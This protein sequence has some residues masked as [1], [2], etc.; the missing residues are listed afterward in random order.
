MNVALLR[1]I[2]NDLPDDLIV[3]TTA[4]DHEY[5]E[6][7]LLYNRALYNGSEYTEWGDNEPTEEERKL[8]GEPVN[9]LVMS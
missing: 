5:R 8:W 9:V 1:E 2:L 6:V 7:Q 3:V 4:P